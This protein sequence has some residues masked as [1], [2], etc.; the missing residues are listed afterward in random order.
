MKRPGL[1]SMIG[2][3]A[4]LG[5]SACVVQ[6]APVAVAP[7]PAPVIYSEPGP[8][9]VHPR[10]WRAGPIGYHLGPHGRRCRPNR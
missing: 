10:R 1:M 4:L 2:I 3:G 7:S 5:L 6:P 8:V 9:V